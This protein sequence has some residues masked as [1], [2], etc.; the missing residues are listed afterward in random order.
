MLAIF[1]LLIFFN[2]DS[3]ILISIYVII[4][5]KESLTYELN[6]VKEKMER[7]SNE[8]LDL[9]ELLERRL[10]EIKSLQMEIKSVSSKLHSNSE[11][12][13]ETSI[14]A[15]EMELRMISIQ[16][17][18]MRMSQ[19]RQLYQKQIQTLTD[20]LNQKV[21]E[22]LVFRRER[23]TQ[24]FELQSNLEQK[25]EEHLKCIDEIKHLKQILDKKDKHI[26][27][28]ATR[29]REMQQ[30]SA[31][32]E[33]DYQNE[34]SAQNNL[35]E[36]HK[37]SS[38]DYK[39][40]NETLVQTI[41]EMQR[42]LQ[43]AKQAHNELEATFNETQIKYTEQINKYIEENNALIK[44][45]EEIKESTAN[46]SREN[47]EAEFEKQYPLAAT[48]KKLLRNNMSFTQIF[49]ELVRAQQ[50]LEDQKSENSV[51]KEH[52]QQ[53]ATEAEDNTPLL[54]R[55]IQEHQRALQNISE[56]QTQISSLL[57]EREQWLQEKD[58]LIRMNKQ[59]EREIK[60][61]EKENIDLAKQIRALIKS[62]Q[63]AR[64]FT[65]SHEQDSQISSSDNNRN[66]PQE[67][68]TFRDI[69][70]LQTKNQQ[71][72]NA[73]RE[74]NEK[75]QKFEEEG[76]DE[77]R[78]AL[79]RD[80]D[81]ALVQLENLRTERRQQTEMVEALV[82]QRD[83]YKMIASHSNDPNQVQ[84][85]P[86]AFTSSPFSSAPRISVEEHNELKSNLDK[87]NKEYAEFREQSSKRSKELSDNNEKLR[88]EI[89]NA[90]IETAKI[91][92]ELTF[93][94]ERLEIFKTNMEQF[95]RE[96]ALLRER[97]TILNENV[98]KHEQSLVLMR[99]EVLSAQD[100]VTRL[101]S[102]LEILKSERDLLRNN[103]L[104][105]LQ[106]KDIMIRNQEN[107]N[108]LIN[109]LQSVQS[110]LNRMESEAIVNLK[111][112]NDKLEKE[113]AYLKSRYDKESERHSEASIL[114]EKHSQDLQTRIDN[115]IEKYLKVNQEL[116]EYQTKVQRLENE[117][118]SLR[119]GSNQ[120]RIDDISDS[121]RA[122]HMQIN[123]MREQY[124]E[125]QNE[126][127]LLRNKLTNAQKACDSL[128]TINSALEEKLNE[129]KLSTEEIQVN[130]NSILTEKDNQ[131]SALKKELLD[132]K[133]RYQKAREEKTSLENEQKNVSQQYLERI[134]KL[135]LSL[136]D[137]NSRAEKASLNEKRVLEDR[138]NQMAI[139]AEAQA[140]YERELQQRSN[141]AQMNNTLRK[142]LEV[143]Q[144]KVIEAESAAK[145]AQEQLA[146]SHQ[147]WDNERKQFDS[148]QEKVK[149]KCLD[150][151]R[152][153]DTLNQQLE[154]LNNRI[155]AL[156]NN[157]SLPLLSKDEAVENTNRLLEVIKFLRKEK[158]ILQT[159]VSALESE[160]SRLKAVV[161]NLKKELIH[162]QNDLKEEKIQSK[163]MITNAS[164]HNELVKKIEMINIL[165][166]SN[167]LL[168][169]EK[170]SLEVKCQELSLK[171]ENIGNQNQSKEIEDLMIKV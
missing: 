56:L 115:E 156:Q 171:L 137:A 18:D 70:E 155:I 161:E 152:I 31:Q 97:N 71:L 101:E 1:L 92:S 38:L 24:L 87:I 122:L 114:W 65:V 44:E 73:L 96:N 140:N 80:L 51:L 37:Q 30:Y 146:Q 143:L 88:E 77:Q 42:L 39:K 34:I 35:I 63:E 48:T 162:T 131:I 6:A 105:L 33:E 117:L 128:R 62:V 98:K 112:R 64:G 85:S 100:K 129:H 27:S 3:F 121:D 61:Y 135:T 2:L 57:T 123:V 36:L 55:K 14:K 154:L 168:R 67:L 11:G 145:K 16:H 148:N 53:L 74:A 169:N 89:S 20:E 151:E 158:E 113:C 106:E 66:V 43:A 41:E 81:E 94:Q 110:N 141:D 59:F 10:D 47:I 134:N 45:L 28:L 103:E 111:S 78:F 138:N 13:I 159:Q 17:Q 126:I 99:Q 90:R 132:F 170:N 104:K 93:T 142:Q 75:L 164:Q 68:V 125:A 120:Q 144:N 19:E 160:D 32:L 12:R 127:K 4:I 72:M 76:T 102:D 60:R 91:S 46:T 133:D 69:V 9:S 107:Q 23:T 50:E 108:K 116:A 130:A 95:Q 149:E 163:T 49:N 124:S 165:S 139:A 22:L 5:G 7:F 150:L 29:I 26:D 167:A 15:E 79:Q 58:T 157:S 86:V 136:I 52:L 153:N 84:R 25:T 83:L 147:I 21:N 166:E 40:R 82:Q 119:N 54:H 8:K 118:N 109:T